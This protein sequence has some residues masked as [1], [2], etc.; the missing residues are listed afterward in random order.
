MCIFVGI[1]DDIADFDDRVADF[2]SHVLALNCFASLLEVKGRL[3][4]CFGVV[5]EAF[6]RLYEGCGHLRCAL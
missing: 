1:C 2:S 3:N 4:I 6:T 5:G